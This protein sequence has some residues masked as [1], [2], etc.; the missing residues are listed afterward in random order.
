MSPGLINRGEGRERRF[1]S[2]IRKRSTKQKKKKTGKNRRK[3]R[4]QRLLTKENTKRE[5]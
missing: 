2:S 5:Q 3:E 4:R 1:V